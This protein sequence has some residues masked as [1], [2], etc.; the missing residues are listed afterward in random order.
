MTKEEKQQ[1][2]RNVWAGGKLAAALG[3]LTVALNGYYHLLERQED[4]LFVMSTK[5][6][7]LSEKVAY[8]EGRM[9]GQS[10]DKVA[11]LVRARAQPAPTAVRPKPKTERQHPM[12]DPTKSKVKLEVLPKPR[13]VAYEQVPVQ[14]EDLRPFR[15]QMKLRSE[16]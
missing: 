10:H 9:E 7:A 15:K 11:P 3:V 6:N 13:D 5:L 4:M 16:E 1:V 8:L 2:R 14:L 12:V